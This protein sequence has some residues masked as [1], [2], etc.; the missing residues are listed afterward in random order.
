MCLHVDG[1]LATYCCAAAVGTALLAADLQIGSTPPVGDRLVLLPRIEE[2]GER[3]GN[4]QFKI[5]PPHHASSTP[6]LPPS[7]TLFQAEKG[8]LHL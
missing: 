5:T 2:E 1:F 4:E 8:H 7:S 6:C 3:G